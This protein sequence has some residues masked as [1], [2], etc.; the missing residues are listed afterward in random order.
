[1]SPEASS[2]SSNARLIQFPVERAEGFY[3]QIP[4]T[5]IRPANARLPE[6]AGPGATKLITNI[7]DAVSLKPSSDK[8]KQFF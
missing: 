6:D 5:A 7:V 4:L 1:M 3:K 2:N 8:K